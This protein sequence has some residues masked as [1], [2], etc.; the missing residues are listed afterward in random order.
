MRRLQEVE[1]RTP[2]QVCALFNRC[3][4]IF[5]YTLYMFHTSSTI[6][7][8]KFVSV[9][10]SSPFRG[11]EGYDCV[12]VRVPHR[13]HR[14]L[15]VSTALN[16]RGTET[17]IVLLSSHST[18]SFSAQ[19]SD[20]C[21]HVAMKTV[22]FLKCALH[23]LCSYMWESYFAQSWLLGVLFHLVQEGSHYQLSVHTW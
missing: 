19:T 15:P 7:N 12:C 10:L 8:Y 3:L 5:L 23:R 18:P 4:I 14:S 6:M 13:I 2:L 21:K 22:I 11:Q 9:P 17:A 20:T 1:H 16:V